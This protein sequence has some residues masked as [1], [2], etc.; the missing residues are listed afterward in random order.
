LA[1]ANAG[2]VNSFI[3]FFWQNLASDALCQRRAANVSHADEEDASHIINLE[4]LV[5]FCFYIKAKFAFF[6]IFKNL[7]ADG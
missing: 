3:F 6:H 5:H 7:D 4:I 2:G 1:I